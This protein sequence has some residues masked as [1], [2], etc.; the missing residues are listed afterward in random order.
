MTTESSRPVCLPVPA[1]LVDYQQWIVTGTNWKEMNSCL[2]QDQSFVWI[3]DKHLVVRLQRDK[4]LQDQNPLPLETR[5]PNLSLGSDS[6]LLLMAS[7]SLDSTSDFENVLA[8][9][10]KF[11]ASMVPVFPWQGMKKLQPW[12]YSVKALSTV[13][14]IL[15]VRFSLTAAQGTALLSKARAVQLLA[16]RVQAG[17][18]GPSECLGI[19]H[20]IPFDRHDWLTMLSSS[21]KL[22]TLFCLDMVVDSV[23]LCLMA[24]NPSVQQ[25]HLSTQHASFPPYVWCIVQQNLER[26]GN[27]QWDIEDATPGFYFFRNLGVDESK[28]EW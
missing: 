19:A 28:L 26:Q 5:G 25:I 15:L 24:R 12:T 2:T 27:L 20:N 17:C 1:S 21:S 11:G 3:D 9:F 18:Q 7:Y 16:C 22:R 13:R 14:C 6:S 4:P 10:D 23:S 8:Y